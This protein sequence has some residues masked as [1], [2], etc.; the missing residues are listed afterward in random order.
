MLPNSVP[1][2][3]D[4]VEMLVSL[5]HLNPLIWRKLRV[6]AEI[7]LNELHEVLQVTFG[8]SNTHLHGYR[9]GD[10]E[11]RVPVSE[12]SGSRFYIDEAGAPLGAVAR[13]G[14]PFIYQYDFGDDWVHDVRVERIVPRAEVATAP[15]IECLG[16]Q[17]RCPPDD[18]GGPPGYEHLLRVLDNPADSEYHEM[19]SWVGRS[20]DP[21]AF[22]MD[23]VNRK[24]ATL[25]KRLGFGKPRVAE[26]SRMRLVEH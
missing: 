19:K 1:Q 14:T 18:C 21:E 16:G 10:L 7:D 23:K 26:S 9:I 13:V 2:P 6:P 8:W 17:R 15:S 11:F 22:D 25:S 12:E 24:L 20:F 3:G 5:R 4:A